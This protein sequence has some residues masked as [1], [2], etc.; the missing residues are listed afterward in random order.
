MAGGEKSGRG[1]RQRGILR[2]VRD[3]GMHRR[4]ALLL[5][6]F[7]GKGKKLYPGK[8]GHDH[9]QP[10]AAVLDMPDRCRIDVT[11]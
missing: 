1:R 11:V 10:D 5:E 4:D 3:G 2:R 6:V 9:L 8:G 7:Y